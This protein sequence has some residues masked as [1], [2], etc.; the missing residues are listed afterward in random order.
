MFS[1][2]LII[3][4]LSLLALLRFFLTKSREWSTAQL[5]SPTK[6]Q[7]LLTWLYYSLISV[8]PQNSSHLLP[9]CL[10]YRF[11]IPFRVASSLFSFSFSSFSLRYSN[12]PCPKGV[13]EDSWERSFQYF[14]LVIWNSLPFSVRHATSSPLSSQ[15]WKP[16]SSLLPTDLSLSF[17]CF[18]Q[19]HD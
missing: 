3:A 1:L 6:L 15:N 8:D 2:G 13:Q 9:H 7:N 16:T 12:F 18:H 4:V 14:E 19:T 10:W 11:S 5:V 17:F